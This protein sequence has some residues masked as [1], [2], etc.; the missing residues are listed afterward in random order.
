L[1]ILIIGAILNFTDRIK[2]GYVIDYF[3]LKYF[4]VFNLADVMICGAVF[5]IFIINFKKHDV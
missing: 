4:T 5:Y 1:T 2:F 3:S